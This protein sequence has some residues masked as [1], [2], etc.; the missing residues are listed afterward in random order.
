MINTSYPVTLILVQKILLPPYY[1]KTTK[2][3]WIL[4]AHYTNPVL[5]PIIPLLKFFQCS[6]YQHR[7][8]LKFLKSD[9]YFPP[10]SPNFLLSPWC[11]LS[12]I[13]FFWLYCKAYGILVTWL[14]IKPLLCLTT[15][16]P[17]NSHLAFLSASKYP[18]SWLLYLIFTFF[19]V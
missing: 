1:L 4:S 16:L 17:G 2:S 11:S 7:T 8:K 3:E 13:I 10:I 18:S 6:P 14:G 19:C 5:C 9:W 12:I 15:V